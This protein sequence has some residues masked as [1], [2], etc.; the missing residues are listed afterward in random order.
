[1]A[2]LHIIQ[3]DPWVGPGEYLAWAVRNGYEISMT[4]C[5]EQETF[6]QD[7]AADLLVILGGHQ[8]PS[9]TTEECPYFDAAQEMAFIR[10]YVDAGKTVVGVCLGA[11]LLGEA[12]GGTFSRSPEPEI[13]PVQARLTEA[14]RRD[15]LLNGFPDTFSAGEWHGDMPGLTKEA[16]ILAESDGCPRQIVRY[17]ERVYG[18]QT[19]MEFTPE[20]IAQCVEKAGNSFA[21]GGRFIQT[22]E[23]LLSFD[24]TEMNRQLDSFLDA[25]ME[26]R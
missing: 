12:L 16:V 3:H 13:G 7:A 10:R 15:P 23:E 24:Y 8:R 19:H 4:K 26:E 17:G 11:Q 14:G 5:W 18:F 25:L 20:I 1:M 22:K 9:T 6:P 2:K 21:A